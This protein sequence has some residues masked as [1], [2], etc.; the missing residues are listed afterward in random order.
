[1]TSFEI[2]RR[3]VIHTLLSLAPPD[4]TTR[5]VDQLT[6][7]APIASRFS[8]FSWRTAL[9]GRYDVFHVHW[10]E[11][12][13]RS[14][15]LPVR[16]VRAALFAAFMLRLKVARIPVVRTL[17][18]LKPHESGTALEK[19]LLAWC[20]ALTTL[21]VRLNEDTPPRK[22]PLRTILHGHYIGRFSVDQRIAST[23]G[24]LL[25]F[26]LIRP[27]KGVERLIEVFSELRAEGLSLRILGNPTSELRT[28]VERACVADQRVSSDLRFVPDDVLGN[29]L[30]LAELVILPYKEMHN[31][32]AVLVA[33][34][35][36]RPVLVPRSR[37]N[38]LL[39]AEV[40]AGWIYMY[41]GDLSVPIIEHAVNQVRS[42]DRPHGA[43]LLSKRDWAVVADQHYLAYA[44][45]MTLAGKE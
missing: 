18:N 3:P 29:E 25:Y 32:G 45:A 20:D 37:S 43:P 1:M 23:Q 33:L 39:A 5:Y 36:S 10:P 17:H 6:V 31:S 16:L 8:F 38:E 2:D 34:S 35:L 11:F 21:D 28:L 9:L 14:P 24:R 12:L 22:K 27:Y 13:L 41:D 4:G 40:G 26:G 30:Q 44:D 19:K 15:H 42:C 7:E